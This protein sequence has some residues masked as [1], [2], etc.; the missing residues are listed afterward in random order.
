MRTWDYWQAHRAQERAIDLEDYRAIGGMAQALSRHADEAY[1]GCR[2][3]AIA[4][5]P[6]ACSRP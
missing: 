1:E 4:I 2:T 5:S 3:I 6:G